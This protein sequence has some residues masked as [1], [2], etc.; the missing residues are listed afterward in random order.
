MELVRDQVSQDLIL[1]TNPQSSHP[2]LRKASDDLWK[3]GNKKEADVKKPVSIDGVETFHSLI[4]LWW[5]PE[6]TLYLKVFQAVYFT[7]NFIKLF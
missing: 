3:Q 1:F 6:G 4:F 2:M 5:L 7:V